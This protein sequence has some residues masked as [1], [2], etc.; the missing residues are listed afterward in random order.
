[1]IKGQVLMK[2]IK[3]KQFGRVKEALAKV[4]FLAFACFSILAVVL[5]CVFLFANGIPAIKEV[6]L[7]KFLTGEVWRP[8]NDIYVFLPMTV[9]ACILR[10]ARFYSACPSAF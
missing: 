9:A 10:P 8:G 6:G 5:I 2:Q 7:F 1:M 3:K 4:L